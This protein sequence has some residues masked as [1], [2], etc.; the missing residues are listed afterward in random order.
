VVGK[1]PSYGGVI[2]IWG[3]VQKYVAAVEASKTAKS[4]NMSFASVQQVSKD[5]LF[6][7]ELKCLSIA[8]LC[9]EFLTKYQNRYS[10]DPTLM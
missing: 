5:L 10:H 7:P 8:K 3:D 6:I 9:Q 1:C 4:N 2:K